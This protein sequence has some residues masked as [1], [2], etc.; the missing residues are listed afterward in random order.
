MT[1]ND[2]QIVAWLAVLV[3]VL[4]LFWRSRRK[5]RKTQQKE[6]RALTIK[7][8]QERNDQLERQIITMRVQHAEL[9]ALADR[10]E[11]GE[12]ERPHMGDIGGGAT[13]M[14]TPQ[15]IITDQEEINRRLFGG[16]GIV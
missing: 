12:E 13:T 9:R 7:V 10:M 8:L 2:I 11:R 5:R 15:G 1:A 6:E 16:G 4:F 3:V 14:F